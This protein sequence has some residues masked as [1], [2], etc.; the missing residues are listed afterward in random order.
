MFM[1]LTNKICKSTYALL[2]LNQMLRRSSFHV[3]SCAEICVILINCVVNDAL[4]KSMSD[5]NQALLQFIDIMNLLDRP[6]HFSLICIVNR[7][8]ICAVG[9]QKSDKI[10]PGVS[11]QKVDCPTRYISRN[12]ALLEDKEP[13]THR[14]HTWH[15]VAFESEAPHGSMR[16]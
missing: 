6:L 14:S 2:E 1:K 15:S 3:N 5:I 7:V 13:P 16:N 11:F 9:W 8:Q 10:N 12:I 4:L